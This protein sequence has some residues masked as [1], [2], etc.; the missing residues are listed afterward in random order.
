MKKCKSLILLSLFSITSCSLF[1]HRDFSDQMDEFGMYSDEPMFRA[2]RDFMVVAGDSGRDYREM[3]SIYRRT[4]ATDSMKKDSLYSRSL[5]RELTSLENKLTDDEYY[6]YLQIKHSLGDISSQIYYLRLSPYEKK[7]YTQSRRLNPV[8]SRSVSS[9]ESSYRN[10]SQGH[11][12][13]SDITV[14]MNKSQVLE[15]MG[16]PTQQDFSDNSYDNAERWSYNSNGSVR[17]IYFANGQVEGWS[18]P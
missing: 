2:N 6:E 16:S 10:K 9:V 8:R 15:L 5:K 11:F 12:V 17:H 18:S 3:G 7:T 1:E 14:G 4:P 13:S